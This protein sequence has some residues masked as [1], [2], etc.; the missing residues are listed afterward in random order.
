MQALYLFCPLLLSNVAS[1]KPACSSRKFIDLRFFQ[2]VLIWVI[3][4]E[5][6]RPDQWIV[7][8]S[9]LSVK[10]RLLHRREVAGN[11]FGVQSP[12]SYPSYLVTDHWI[13][14]HCLKALAKRLPKEVRAFSQTSLRQTLSMN[15]TH[16]QRGDRVLLVLTP[17][18]FELCVKNHFLHTQKQA[19]LWYW[20]PKWSI[21]INTPHEQ[22]SASAVY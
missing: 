10:A 11:V 22:A 6:L 4:S 14:G 2:Q 20:P 7:S 12:N 1:R 19:K 5:Q 3:N 13:T 15:S 16:F 18:S 17:L 21:W 9:S 8:D